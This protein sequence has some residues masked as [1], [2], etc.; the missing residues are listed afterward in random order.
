MLITCPSELIIGI[1][2]L[3]ISASP[4]TFTS[5]VFLKESYVVSPNNSLTRYPALLIKISILIFLLFK[6]AI[7]SSTESLFVMSIA[8]DSIPP[9]SFSG[10]IFLETDIT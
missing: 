8:N 9:I 10:S 4:N 3:V 2:D 5:N 7:N 1:R 6:F